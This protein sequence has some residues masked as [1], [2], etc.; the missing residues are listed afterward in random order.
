M[1]RSRSADGRGG[2]ESGQHAITGCRGHG[3]GTI[4]TGPDGT[5]P[6]VGGRTAGGGASAQTW[7]NSI[8]AR[9]GI[10]ARRRIPLRLR[11]EPGCA[12]AN[13]PERKGGGAGA[14]VRGSALSAAHG[15]AVQDRSRRTHT[16]VRHLEPRP[17]TQTGMIE[18]LTMH[19][20][21]SPQKKFR[22]LVRNILKP[23]EPDVL[24]RCR[25]RRG[26]RAGPGRSHGHRSLG[27][28]PA[29]GRF[30]WRVGPEKSKRLRPARQ[31]GKP[32]RE[33]LFV[34]SSAPGLD[35]R[36]PHS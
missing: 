31:L 21:Y 33:A 14:L 4:S 10:A 35:R 8:A 22:F 7:R 27:F 28:P 20:Q 18:A 1:V 26:L 12:G 23:G 16:Q 15:P 13:L 19:R 24:P 34:D 2:S 25:H 32:K 36:T 17:V 30:G 3:S 6:A 29:R 5:R 9:P 11:E